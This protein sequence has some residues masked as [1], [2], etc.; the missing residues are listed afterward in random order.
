MSTGKD[1]W[2]KSA[3]NFIHS[4]AATYTPDNRGAY[5]KFINEVIPHILPCS[6]CR[7]HF[8][9]KIKEFPPDSYLGNNHDL[10]FWTYMIHDMVNVATK[11]APSPPFEEIKTE[12][13]SALKADCK[14]CTL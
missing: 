14:D 6:V 9:E 4:T 7:K 11:K 8:S 1:F 2:G 3:W 5:E 12:Y 10:F 13:Y